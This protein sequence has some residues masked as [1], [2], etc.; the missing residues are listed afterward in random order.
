M[1]NPPTESM[2]DEHHYVVEFSTHDLGFGLTEN[3]DPTMEPVVTEPF[4]G[5]TV[6]SRGDI[7]L[8]INGRF[9][10]MPP[11]STRSRGHK[12]I[13]SQRHR[14]YDYALQLIASIQ[15][16]PVICAFGKPPKV[17]SVREVSKRN[18]RVAHCTRV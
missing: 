4:P 16:P 11:D 2:E 10:G 1:S 12:P 8:S 9:L 7:L 13:V 14:P 6:M 5:A 18:P 3:V 17:P 15:Q